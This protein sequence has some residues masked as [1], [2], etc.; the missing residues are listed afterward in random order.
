MSKAFSRKFE[1]RETLDGLLALAGSP[2]D[3]EA[4]L[5]QM[6]EAT[7]DG[8]SSSELI[9]S[10]FDGEPRFEDPRI[11]QKLFENLL[12]LWDLVAGGGPIRLDAKPVR[13]EKE[14][15]AVPEVPTPLGDAEPD[16][17]FV[18]KAWRYL[19]EMPE[20]DKEKWNH[21][22]ENR[23]DGLLTFLDESGL[24]DDGYACARHLLFELFV[25]IELG[26][27]PG[28]ANV[29]LAMLATQDDGAV[30]PLPETFSDYVEESLFEAENDEDAPREGDA[31]AQV[32]GV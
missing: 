2:L 3:S 11:A 10:L 28:V 30:A 32:K 19:E 27:L 31:L 21:A 9:P 24:S 1:G 5:E 7:R 4:V 18:E 29:T 6:R 14:K 22:F 8:V 23:Q 20:R 17:G 25:M 13:K 12:G 15:K 26:W 16:A